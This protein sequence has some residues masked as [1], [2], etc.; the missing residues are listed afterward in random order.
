[1]GAAF[2]LLDILSVELAFLQ[3]KGNEVMEEVASS[4]EG[5]GCLQTVAELLS[6]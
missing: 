1:M 4:V 2:E 5:D 3:K 6:F